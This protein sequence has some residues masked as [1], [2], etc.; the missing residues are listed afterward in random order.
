MSYLD[1]YIKRTLRLDRVSEGEFAKR[2]KVLKKLKQDVKASL[3]SLSFGDS[4]KNKIRVMAEISQL[5]D[6]SFGIM[7]KKS[8][9]IAK[10]IIAK[11]IAW[12]T[13]ILGKYTS[14]NIILPS[15]TASI[16]ELRD[17]AF[18]GKTFKDWYKGTSLV[19]ADDAIKAAESGILQGQSVTEITAAVSK[20][21][22]KSGHHIRTL[23]RSQIMSTAN[24]AREI[25]TEQNNDLFGGKIWISTLD[26]RTTVDICGP[27]DQ[28]EY[29]M[30][31]VPIGHQY[32]WDLGPGMIH[33]NCRSTFVPKLIGID[34]QAP[35]PSIGAGED[36][37]RGDNLT[38]TGRVRK[39]TKKNRDD[40]IFKITI[41][42][43]GTN[44]EKWLRTQP[45]D[46]VAD[47]FSSKE[48]AKLFKAGKSLSSITQK[49]FGTHLTI[50]Q[51]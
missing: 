15:T 28:L 7:E 24:R 36:Y 35:R 26:I 2:A 45:K 41:K 48:K 46:F 51:L 3:E 17:A 31:N 16:S 27:R 47:V 8:E 23:V 25:V 33:F 20:V 34:L 42:Q 5:F 18:Q 4:G 30:D 9:D 13:D 29:T 14:K 6:D 40:G 1:E 19:D 11:E 12:H 44:Y 32:S 50:A 39:P 49:P 21:I 22:N 43:K 10:E 37:K 38:S